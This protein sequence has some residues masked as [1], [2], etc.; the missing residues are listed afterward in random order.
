MGNT[1]ISTKFKSEK[2]VPVSP[3]LFTTVLQVLA[4][5]ESEIG[6]TNGKVKLFADDMTLYVRKRPYRTFL[7]T[8]ISTK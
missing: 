6:D 4:R 7:V 1:S 2:R 3:R 8:K 5:F